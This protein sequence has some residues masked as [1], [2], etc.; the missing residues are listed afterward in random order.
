MSPQNRSHLVRKLWEEGG[1]H[2]EGSMPGQEPS[3]QKAQKHRITVK[4]GIIGSMY[5]HVVKGMAPVGGGGPPSPGKG[6]PPEDKPDNGS[7]EE[8]ND[9]TYTDEETVSVTSSSQVSAGKMK[10]RK[11]DKDRETYN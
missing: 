1:P 10:Q 3:R 9:E 2:E 8:E 6:G 11:W 7:D 5:P 4:A